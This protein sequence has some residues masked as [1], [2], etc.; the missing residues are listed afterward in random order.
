MARRRAFASRVPPV[1]LASMH[2][3][4]A[5]SV[6]MASIAV[7]VT[8]VAFNNVSDYGSNFQFVRHVLQMDTTFGGNELMWRA[9]TA[10]NAHHAAY[11]TIISVECLI[12]GLS[13]FAAWRLWMT[14][15][16]AKAFR[17]SK[18]L[19]NG[20]LVAGV[21]LW[22]TGFIAIGGEWFLMWQSET[23]NG[24]QAAY[25]IATVLLLVLIFINMDD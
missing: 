15:G 11:V 17:A 3:R 23:W 6:L 24:I 7:Y 4:A 8:L 5:K 19:A 9:V 22:F 25:R 14:R 13:W 18:Q 10:R 20:A 2:P 1:I 21:V 12:A 16:E